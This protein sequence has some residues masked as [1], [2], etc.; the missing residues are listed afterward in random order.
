[1]NDKARKKERERECVAHPMCGP[2]CSQTG[3]ETISYKLDRREEWNRLCGKI[4][5]KQLEVWSILVPV[6]LSL[7]FSILSLDQIDGPFRQVKQ[8]ITS[9]KTFRIL[10]KDFKEYVQFGMFRDSFRDNQLPVCRFVFYLKICC[11]CCCCCCL[12][13]LDRFSRSIYNG[14]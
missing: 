14:E 5:C 11:S 12:I 3:R 13:L 2:R 7:S 9:L 4:V 6:P 10:L 8:S 1:M